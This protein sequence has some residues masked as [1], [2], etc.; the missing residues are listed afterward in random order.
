M[1]FSSVGG[2]KSKVIDI[3]NPEVYYDTESDPYTIYDLKAKIPDIYSKLT[4]ENFSIVSIDYETLSSVSIRI[5]LASYDAKTGRLKVNRSYRKENNESR[6]YF[7]S[8]T[9]RVVY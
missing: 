3:K 8:I 2:R 1:G 4:L 6:M 7:N 5:N 9:F